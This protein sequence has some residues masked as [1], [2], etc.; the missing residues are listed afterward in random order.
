MPFIKSEEQFPEQRYLPD[1]PD[2][3]I[4]FAQTLAAGFRQENVTTSLIAAA[5]SDPGSTPPADLE[6]EPWDN[7]Q[8]YEEFAWDLADAR[9]DEHMAF[10]KGR[11]DQQQKDRQVLN[12]SGWKGVVSSMAAAV[13]DPVML[14]FLFI[15]YAGTARVGSVALRA[16]GA[17]GVEATVAEMALHSQQATRT[18]LE[19]FFNIGGSV[20][21]GGALGKAAS[22]L[23]RSRLNAVVKATDEYF[24]DTHQ[25]GDVPDVDY[26]GKSVGAATVEKYTDEELALYPG[27]T[28]IKFAKL[29]ALG[30]MATSLSP[31]ARALG[32]NIAENAF[33]YTNLT[34]NLRAVPTAVESYIKRWTEGSYGRGVQST[35]FHYKAYRKRTKGSSE[36]RFNEAQ[37]RTEVGRA[38]RR[39]SVHAV[40]EV[41][42]AAA[43]WRREVFDPLLKRGMDADLFGRGFEP[44]NQSR[45]LT[46]VYDRGRLKKNRSEFE[47]ILVRW[48]AEDVKRGR[49]AAMTP[50][51]ISSEVS[52]ITDT[53]MGWHHG[54]L[55]FFDPKR[56]GKAGSM[57]ER[58]LRIPDELIEDF[59]VSDI[60]YIGRV[61]TRSIAPRAE[62]AHLSPSNDWELKDLIE[63]MND[64][65]RKLMRVAETSGD[66]KTQARLTKELE[67]Q[68]RNVQAMRDRLIGT[69]DMPSDP[70][71]WLSRVPYVIK[72][73]NYL[74]M[75][76]GMTLSSLPD[77]ARPI[78]EF[79]LRGSYGKL[80]TDLGAVVRNWSE[81]L[82]ELQK[83]GTA[84]DIVMAS[85]A[86]A[87]ADLD[88]VQPYTKFTQGMESVT[89]KFTRLTL[90]SDW[91][92]A[93]KGFTGLI[94]QDK[95]LRTARTWGQQ[96]REILSQ[97]ETARA[98]GNTAEIARLQARQLEVGQTRDIQDLL[99]YGIDEE[100]A[101]RIGA[102]KINDSDSL[103][104][105]NTDAWTDVDAVRQ[106]RAALVKMADTTIVTPGVGDMPRFIKGDTLKLVTQF[107]SFMMATV[108]RMMIPMRQGLSEGDMRVY[109]GIA[110]SLAFGMA[111][112]VAKMKIAGREDEIQWDNEGA[113]ISE[114]IDRS[115]MLGPLMELYTMANRVSGGNMSLGLLTGDERQR[116]SR[117]AQRNMWGAIAGP[118]VGKGDDIF[119]T[120]AAALGPNDITRSD[121]RAFQKL[122]PFRNL[123]FVNAIFSDKE[124]VDAMA[125]AVGAKKSR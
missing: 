112:Y 69:Y 111:T 97:I 74:T 88:E 32:L 11:I 62:L 8:G 71:T 115:G 101:R 66:T 68:E 56:V 41:A 24:D 119:N 36:P 27:S 76:G 5:G 47:R 95:M 83:A 4:D 123:L 107:R 18:P 113:L 19:S 21:V 29:N 3:D 31:V 2:A 72:S 44:E 121:V 35:G 105:A 48:I 14:P 13:L 94:G 104:L 109:N 10:L 25:L 118:T 96:S 30:Q 78:F 116:V 91:N 60:N 75:M 81:G 102:E 73:W 120:M 55:S 84:M 49:A 7:M 122:I 65:I 61:Y 79:G 64:D 63:E 38:L 103:W 59:L 22:V 125:G 93:L 117:Y 86:K 124:I 106:F 16:A 50:D 28:R 6:Y 77:L 45:Y 42:E 34:K 23:S 54:Q 58:V 37:F 82:E 52:D 100:M 15:P 43:Y 57:H 89:N 98:A 17:V 9:S 85:R 33:R 40:S 90:M 20:L 99:R 110:M 1:M 46:R 26:T 12:M 87:I 70:T 114:A 92:T 39:G 67:F 108:N 51:E 53:L 80:T